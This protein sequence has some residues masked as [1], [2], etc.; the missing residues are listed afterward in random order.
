MAPSHNH[1]N[2]NAVPVQTNNNQYPSNAN[3]TIG[4][5]GPNMGTLGA[6]LLTSSTSTSSVPKHPSSQNHQQQQSS[7]L[8][9]PNGIEQAPSKLGNLAPVLGAGLSNLSGSLPSNNSIPRM[10]CPKMGMSVVRNSNFNAAPSLQLQNTN[11]SNT[12]SAAM[13]LLQ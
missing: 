9:G 8:N 3:N 13:P 10:A 5:I 12:P 1:K 7:P 4:T 2:N 6:N 11:N